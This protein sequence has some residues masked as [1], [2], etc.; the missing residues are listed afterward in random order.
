V[1]LPSRRANKKIATE[2]QLR[3]WLKTIR[4]AS[5]I[6]Y[7]ASLEID[8]DHMKPKEAAKLI[9]KHYRL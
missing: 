9:K 7:V 4:P 1:S 8:T 3:F 6:P 5:S 2:K